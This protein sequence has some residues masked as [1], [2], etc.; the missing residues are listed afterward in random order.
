V[1]QT[2]TILGRKSEFLRLFDKMGLGGGLR[3][4]DFWKISFLFLILTTCFGR[5]TNACCL[6]L[7]LSLP[8]SLFL[9]LSLSFACTLPLSLSCTWQEFFGQ[10]LINVYFL[11]FAIFCK[12]PTCLMCQWRL[13]IS[14]Y[15]WSPQ[16]FLSTF[17]TGKCAQIGRFVIVFETH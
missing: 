16:L 1:R 15:L 3:Q 17:G 14:K 10:K 11:T 13:A 7:S 9:S 12:T 4:K 5:W 8:L 2:K 6:A